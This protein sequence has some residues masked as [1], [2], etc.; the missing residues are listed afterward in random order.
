LNLFVVFHVVVA[1][2][3]ENPKEIIQQ[4]Y[5]AASSNKAFEFLYIDR[6]VM[7]PTAIAL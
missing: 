3:R 2:A 7:N 1:F 6:F 4:N 5:I